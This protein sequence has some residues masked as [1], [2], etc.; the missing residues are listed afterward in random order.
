[1]DVYTAFHDPSR[2]FA[3]TVGGPFSVTVAGGWFPRH[4]LGRAHALCAYIR[5]ALVAL[6]IAW[7][8]WRRGVQYDVIITDQVST[9]GWC[10]L[11]AVA[12]ARLGRQVAIRNH[13]LWAERQLQPTA[14]ACQLCWLLHPAAPSH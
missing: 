5:C 12:R 1:M 13:R 10:C 3:E 7:L 6:Y 4:I 9:I 11:A 2:C 14:V 8:S